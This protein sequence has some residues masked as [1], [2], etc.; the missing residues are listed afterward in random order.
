MPV[1][2]VEIPGELYR[3]W[4]TN[5]E[6][7]LLDCLFIPGNNSREFFIRVDVLADGEEIARQI[8]RELCLDAAHLLEFCMSEEVNLSATND[9][10]SQK[11]AW[12]GTGS[13][14]IRT[15]AAIVLQ[16]PPTTEQMKS[17]T[18]AQAAFQTETDPEKKE[19]LLRAIHWQASG[20]QEIQSAIDRFIKFWIALEIVV[21][22]EGP[23]VVRKVKEQLM[24]LYPK[25]DEQRLTE[26]IGRIYGVRADIV[27]FG[28]RQS[29]DLYDKLG[30]LE[31][32]L[33]DLLRARLDLEFK[34]LAERFLV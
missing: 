20:R 29:Q 2:Q 31:S 15:S 1:F 3:N 32:I 16:I 9:R 18:R 17:I 10:V 21:S 5:T 24:G 28:M 34:A 4:P 8:G 12:C 19:S 22:G 11:G 7:K 14:S 25:A 6:I 33:E 27:H 13:S 30:Q 23:K 26:I